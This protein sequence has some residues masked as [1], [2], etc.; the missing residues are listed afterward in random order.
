MTHPWGEVA[1]GDTWYCIGF[2][3]DRWCVLCSHGPIDGGQE[4][5]ARCL[6][7]WIKGDTYNNET[8]PEAMVVSHETVDA[9]L[10]ILNKVTS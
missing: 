3:D 6:E 9:T 5:A 2:R 7:G 10:M 4:G 1:D 8:H